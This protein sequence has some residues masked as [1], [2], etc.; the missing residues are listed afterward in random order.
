MIRTLLTRGALVA[1]VLCVPAR[2]FAQLDDERSESAVES[3]AV[4]PEEER[5]NLAEEARSGP[6]T[7]ALILEA[8]VDDIE[9]T[10][11]A[12]HRLRQLVDDTPERDPTRA[13]YMFRLAELYYDRA[14]Y[15][16]QRA[17]RRRDDAYDLR[18]LNPQRAV[19]YEEAANADLEQSD[20]FAN[21]AIALYADIY[22]QY[23]D[24][25][26]DIDAVLYYLGA[27]MLQLGQNDA[28]RIVFEDL[29]LNHP[30][31][32]YLAQALLMLGELLFVDGDMEEARVY[33]EAVTQFPDSTGYPY[34]LYKLAWVEYNLARDAAGYE[35]AIQLLYDAIA[36][37]E[38]GSTPSTIR[39]R[40]DALRDMTLFY[41]EVYPASAAL[42][43]F[44]QIAPDEAFDL[45]ARLARI[46]GDRAAYE[47]S[48]TLYRTLI[49]L[50][51][52][53]FDIVEY[54]REIVRNTRPMANDV[55]V[56][57]ETRRLV[58]LYRLA[59]GFADADAERVAATGRQ[60]EELVRALATT[61]HREGQVTANET[62]YALAFA[63]Y[64]DYVE[65]FGDSPYAYQM[66]FYYG[67]LLYRNESW[68]AAARAYDRSLALSTPQANQ[69]DEESTHAA[70][71]AYSNTVDLSAAAT[72]SAGT[73]T[74]DED[75]LPPVPEPREIPETYTQMMNA[76][77]RYLATT[78]DPARAAEVEYVVAFL[79]Y[80]YDHL[81]EAANRFGAIALDHPEVT[82]QRAVT[83]AEL[84]LD[85]LALARRFEDMKVWIDRFKASARLNTDP[86]FSA[87]LQDLSA[88]V[89]FR[90]CLGEQTDLKYEEAGHCFIGFVE[91]HFDSDLRCRGLYNAALAF[92][93][94]AKL[95][96]SISAMGYLQQYCPDSDLVEEITYQLGRTYH[97]MAMYE[98]AASQYELYYQ[99]VPRGENVRSA[100]A[101][102]AE[103]RA[104][105]SQWTQAISDYEAYIRVSNANDAEER[106]GIA[107]ATY[108]I[109]EVNRQRGETRD[110]VASFERVAERY[111]RVLPSRA[112]ES[113]VHI[114]DIT[115]ASSAR[116]SAARALGQYRDAVQ[117]FAGL[118][119][120]A[121][122]ELS[123]AATDAAARAAFMQA[124][125]IYKEFE[126]IEFAGTEAQV[127]AA[128]TR[129]LQLG[130]DATAA[131]ADIM[132]TY[133][134]PGWSIAAF[135]RL[136]QMYHIF[137][138]ELI[139]AP[140]PA[141]L[142]PVEE[143]AYR[144]EI[145]ARAEEVKGMAM[146][147]YAAAIEIARSTGWFNEYSEL[148]AARY[149]ELDPTF[150]AG[151]EV[152]VE[153]G[154]DTGVVPYRTPLRVPETL[155][156][157][158]VEVEVEAPRRS[159]A[160]V[161]PAAPEQPAPQEV[162]P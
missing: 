128:V 102:A 144:S 49:G 55:E 11:T 8:Q 103:F 155:E 31:S 14:R 35:H 89:D 159:A 41:S 104:G 3:F 152:R 15:Y 93:L 162:A 2:A 46:Y 5:A 134:R 28:A 18:D 95:D 16:E 21:Q 51:S 148:A 131:Y 124:E 4:A 154:F 13:E 75:E 54:Q 145:E 130:T 142:S 78:S 98:R 66:W 151:A 73:A 97:R 26:D 125:E 114:A 37:T 62:L 77:N 74:T 113:L 123:P 72:T 63:L 158:D 70:C 160:P 40:R 105:L 100:L 79:Y 10:E 76:C 133:G 12:L 64:G 150:K 85:S 32:A 80:N 56:V 25:Y 120:E 47:D 68:E 20:A 112:I 33:Y 157:G 136:G 116:G 90:Q 1:F 122:A 6:Q 81:D 65:V 67:E 127:Q 106:K 92:D 38:S 48:N 45:V 121:R 50:N 96:Y 109:A 108:Q 22:E 118:S 153:P 126:G 110:A 59:S 99:R 34:A 71:V 44:T 43:F 119:P 82:D 57:R 138:E 42:E 83:S 135:A 7:N 137:F 107:E 17:Y 156:I 52:S 129:R 132:Q 94:A 58:E 141:G 87:L 60:I 19:A 149:T 111:G 61:Y 86:E 29:A 23:Y 53:S 27:N 115:A 140:V 30:N 117:A 84:A 161:V 146:Q 91:N 147:Q 39:I 101:N 143:E 88:Q 9:R 24:T 36:A 69:F 139:D